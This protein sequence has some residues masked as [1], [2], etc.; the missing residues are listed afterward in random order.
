MDSTTLLMILGLL[1]AVF[2]S[3]LFSGLE[4]GIYSLNTMRLNL[5]AD[6]GNKA[7]KRLRPFMSRYETL[8]SSALIGTNIADYVATACMTAALLHMS[9]GARQ[10]ELYATAVVT[11][12]ILVFGNILPK[13]RFRVA[14]DQWMYPLSWFVVTWTRLTQWTGL[15]AALSWLGRALL[16]VLDPSRAASERDLLPRARMMRGLREGMERGGLSELQR[17]A[18]ERVMRLS[19]MRVNAVM[20]PLARAAMIPETIRREDFLR[21]ARMAHFSRLPV[22]RR[23]TRDVIGVVHVFDV[24][25]DPEARPVTEHM[26]EIHT[27]RPNETVPAALR[28]MQQAGQTMAV[29]KNLQGQCIGLLTIKDLVEEIVGEIEVW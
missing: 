16:S 3:G 20:V 18:F 12:L 24:L 7:A 4:M 29:V 15:P 27:M 25:A 17:E 9:V 6:R 1:L 14:T 13:E 10:A 28:Q 11:P 5:L 22:Y 23:Q 19:G 8:V 2:A 21:I 26:R